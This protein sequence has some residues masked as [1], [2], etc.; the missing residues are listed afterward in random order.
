MASKVQNPETAA[1]LNQIADGYR[2]LRVAGV[3]PETSRD[4]IVVAREV[5]QLRRAADASAINVLAEIDDCRW[6]IADGHATPKAMVAHHAKLSGGEAMMR[7]RLAAVREAMPAVWQLYE[8]GAI[9]S[10]HM[11]TIAMVHS[12]P[13][14]R[15]QLAERE[16][17]VINE[18]RADH[19]TFDQRLHEWKRLT[20][21]DGPTPPNQRAHE[22]RDARIDQDYDLIWHIT[23]RFA[24][25][26]GFQLDEILNHYI[27]AE[28]LADW[29]KARAE[30]GDA[31]VVDDL[32]RTIRQRRADA[33][34]QI[35]MDAAAN[36][37]S[38]VGPDFVHNI[39]WDANTFEKLAEK[40]LGPH[41]DDDAQAD[42]ACASTAT[43]SDDV[44]EP[45][46]FDEIDPDTMVCQT[47]DGV[48][49]EPTEMMINAVSA[50]IRRVIFEA[51]P[52]RVDLGKAR[53]FTGA[54]RHAVKLKATHCIWPGCHVPTSRC[55]TDHIH[56]HSQNG[57]TCPDN[58]APLCGKH[59][60]LKHNGKFTVYR[61]PDGLWHT[62][63]RDGTE[64]PDYPLPRR[65]RPPLP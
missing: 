40:V 56:E 46:L 25:E 30:H 23:A 27:E 62:L 13:R 29:E 15:H 53:G 6:H 58:G 45:S 12:N 24:S 55:Q 33:L 51:E 32:P 1:A 64:I 21:E 36:P 28:T 18:A 20:D 5:E 8:V 43:N 16:T 41:L 49:L 19:N 11:R 54:A 57:R 17:A 44:D 3:R 22:D 50:T 61:S 31:A 47:I 35:F 39:V 37:N 59:N 34:W 63:R 9:G 14:V 2:K 48:R 38:A 42:I 65:S 4:A 52:E 26:Q 10:D 60:R 7:K